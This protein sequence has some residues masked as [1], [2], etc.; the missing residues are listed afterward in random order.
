[1]A[2]QRS[3]QERGEGMWRKGAPPLIPSSLHSAGEPGLVGEPYDRIVDTRT[4]RTE[5]RRHPGAYRICQVVCVG[6]GADRACMTYVPFERR[7]KD[8]PG[9]LFRK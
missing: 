5:V 8:R 6:A 4:G 1:M 3:A 7:Y 2:L 9:C